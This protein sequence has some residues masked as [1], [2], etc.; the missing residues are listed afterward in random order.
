MYTRSPKLA[1]CAVS[2]LPLVALVNKNYGDW[3]NYNAVTVQE[4]LAKVTVVSMEV[5]SSVKIVLGLSSE[6]A[7]KNRYNQTIENLYS[8]SMRQVC[9]DVFHLHFVL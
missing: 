9:P 1:T 2:L 7:E 6:E 8:V 4:A 5:L 3:L